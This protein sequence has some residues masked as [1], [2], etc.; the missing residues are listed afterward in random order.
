MDADAGG[1]V[2]TEAAPDTP[3]LLDSV[4]AQGI[5]VNKILNKAIQ[6]ASVVISTRSNFWHAVCTFR[7]CKRH[8]VC[9]IG[10]GYCSSAGR[11]EKL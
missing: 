8:V 7:H 1:F 11:R 10:N 4:P 5:G 3:P 2:P 9:I 6:S